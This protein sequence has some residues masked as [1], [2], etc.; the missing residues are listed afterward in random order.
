MEKNYTQDD[1]LAVIQKEIDSNS[2][3]RVAKRIGLSAGF[4]SDVMNGNR[5]V[6]DTVAKA[7]GFE[8]SVVT[9]VTFRRAR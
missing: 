2:L 5:Q 8:R 1:V 7:F 9:V 4:M 3:R 6:T